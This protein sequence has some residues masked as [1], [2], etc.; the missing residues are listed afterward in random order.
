MADQPERH[1][2]RDCGCKKFFTDEGEAFNTRVV[3]CEEHEKLAAVLRRIL[4]EFDL[5]LAD[6]A[7]QEEKP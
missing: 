7:R 2:D 5:V 6:I 3:W 4:D 1:I